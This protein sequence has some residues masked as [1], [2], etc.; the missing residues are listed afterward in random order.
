VE[1]LLSSESPD[2]PVYAVEAAAETGNKTYEEEVRKRAV[3]TLLKLG[4][5]DLG[6]LGSVAVGAA[7][8]ALSLERTSAGSELLA[9]ARVAATTQEEHLQAE[10]EDEEA[11]TAAAGE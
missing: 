8:R 10:L 7:E 4:E 11:T 2:A 1:T 9:E 3:A 6:E 5:E